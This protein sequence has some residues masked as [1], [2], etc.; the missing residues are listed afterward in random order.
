M[1]RRP[2]RI[3]KRT[4]LLVF[5]VLTTAAVLAG[6]SGETQAEQ[7]A[8]V[9]PLHLQGQP[10]FPGARGYGAM[11]K[12]GREGEIFF[13]D[14]LEDSGFGTLRECVEAKMPRV[15]IFRVSGTIRFNGRPPVIR[16]PYL[17]I[18]GQTAPGGGITLAHSGGEFGFTP[19]LIKETHDIVVRHIRIRNDR[20]G[21]PNNRGGEDSI[22][23]ENSRKVIIDHVSASWAR[24]EI[25]NGFADNDNI[26]ISDSIFAEGIPK[27]DKCALLASDPVGPQRLSFIG[28]LCAHNGDRNPDMNFP[29]ASCVEIVNNVFYNAQSQ[30]AEVWES[31]GGTPVSIVGNVFRAG[32]NTS[33]HTVGIDREVIGSNGLAT[34]FAEGNRFDGQ[35]VRQ[36]AKVDEILADTPPCPL[37]LQPVSADAAYE[38]VLDSAGA[39]PRDAFDERVVRNVR[40]QTGH[41]KKTPGV[42]PP[43]AA[44][45]PYVDTDMDGMADDWENTHGA[46]V[47]AKD[48]WE[49]ADSDGISNLDAFLAFLSDRL[50]S[51]RDMASMGASNHMISA[52]YAETNY[53]F[54]S[55]INGHV[56]KGGKPKS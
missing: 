16:N 11:A 47:G 39:W 41:I 14:S 6:C 3:A 31:Y 32:P 21:T 49:D 54:R 51:G 18:A 43:A 33:D 25:I 2:L 28:N 15:C 37:T 26:T 36:S 48:S 38:A 23:I 19:L 10:A 53:P 20:V 34:I 46:R 24:D 45:T 42:I 44:G 29:P 13:V 50:V 35:F 56:S 55:A 17:T 52:I 22:T 27:H 5:H 4:R 8:M 1:S 12:G 40:K 30:F 7:Y 9:Q